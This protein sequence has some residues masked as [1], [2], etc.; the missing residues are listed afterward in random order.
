VTP[1]NLNRL[2][3]AGIGLL[4]LLPVLGSYLLYWFWSPEEHVNYGTLLEPRPVAGALH[5]VDGKPFDWQQL[6][7]RWALVVIDSGACAAACERKL[8]LIRQVRQAQGEN[9]RRVERVWLIEDAQPPP[10]RLGQEYA[11]TWFVAARAAADL[12]AFGAASGRREQIYLIDPLGN[13]IMRFPGDPD[14]KRLIR[15]L[16]RL[17]KYSSVG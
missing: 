9:L 17:L 10:A 14:P 1:R 12:E 4:A 8:W 5:Q 7:G 15:D 16:G 6:R 13:L 3:V 11:G 2:K